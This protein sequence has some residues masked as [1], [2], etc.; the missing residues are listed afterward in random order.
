MSYNYYYR[1]LMM[2]TS[3]TDQRSKLMLRQ[4]YNPIKYIFIL[5]CIRLQKARIPYLF[6]KQIVPGVFRITEH[7]K[8]I[9]L[10]VHFTYFK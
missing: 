1:N 7:Q 8:L 10:W 2:T 9:N 6:L 3:T 5:I 4:D